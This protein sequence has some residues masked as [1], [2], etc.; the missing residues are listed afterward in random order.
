MAMLEES[1][2]STRQSIREHAARTRLIARIDVHCRAWTDVRSTPR[3]GPWMERARSLLH[4]ARE[5]RL[6]A[7]A[8]CLEDLC[9][10]QQAR[11]RRMVMDDSYNVRLAVR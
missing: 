3:A 11:S 7:A 4:E 9:R 6:V 5:R 8:Q 2:E 10:H 1:G